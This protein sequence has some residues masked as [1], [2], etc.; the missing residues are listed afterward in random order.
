MTTPISPIQA[1]NTLFQAAR[2]SQQTA[3]V[4]ETING[5][6]QALQALLNSLSSVDQ[7]ILDLRAQVDSL[8]GTVEQL[9]AEA[10]KAAKE[11]VTK[12]GAKAE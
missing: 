11:A 2:Q 10:K 8:T 6:Y 4:H 1:V 7:M 3:D 5:C 12:K 9:T